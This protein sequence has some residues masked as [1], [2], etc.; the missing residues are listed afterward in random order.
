M[1]DQRAQRPSGSS[2]VPA[3]PGFPLLGALPIMKKDPLKFLLNSVREYGDVVCLGGLPSQKYY[4]LNDPHDIERVFKTRH[5]EYVRG[6][7]FQLMRDLAGNGLFLNEG[8]SWSRQRKLL[9][10]AFHMQRLAAM[11]GTM[12]ETTAEMVGRWIAVARRRET[13]EIEREVTG[14]ALDLAVK[15]LFGCEVR[16]QS[17]AV[18]EAVTVALA[19]IYERVWSP[20][21]LPSWLPTP[22]NRR[23]QRA[24]ATIDAV[25]YGLIEE[26]RSSGRLGTDVLSM[27]LTVRDEDGEAM[28]D[29]QIRDEVVNLMVAGHETTALAICWTLFL[30]SKH[31][32]VERR[33]QEELDALGGSPPTMAE[34]PNLRY[35]TMVLRES[36]RLYPPF[37]MFTRSPIADDE[38]GGHP[39]PAGSILMVSPYVTHRHLDYWENPEAFDPERFAPEREVSRPLFAYYPFGHGPRQCIG[40]RMADLECLLVLAMVLQRLRLTLVPGQRVEPHPSLSL[41][42]KSGFHM[43]L[44]ERQTFVS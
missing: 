41:R 2:E 15:T 42:S 4:F 17:L 29:R 25:V 24:I 31:P 40:Q 37:W 8:E 9:Q 1:A 5:R 10:P 30:I 22:A 12:T 43:A 32:D 14:L 7:N 23:F 6:A 3:P 35:L 36:L 34:I 11:V 44:H 28:P 38:I 39:I 21:N 18:R 27:L 26:R 20:A 33:V 13:L 16:E 19:Y